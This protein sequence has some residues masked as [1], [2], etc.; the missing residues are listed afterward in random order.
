MMDERLIISELCKSYGRTNVLSHLSMTLEP[1]ITGLLGA[2]GAGK[3]T[4]MR[5]LAT[6]QKPDSGSITYGQRSWKNANDVRALVGYIPQSFSMYPLLTV[7]EVLVHIAHMKEIPTKQIAAE[8][9]RVLQA[10]NLTREK[11]KYVKQLSGGMLRRLG[12]AQC[13]LGNPPILLLDE[14]T[15]GLDP[16]EQMR[17]RKMLRDI[18]GEHI[19]LL[20]SHIVSDIE[21]VCDRYAILFGQRIFVEGDW[22]DA[23][24]R[25]LESIYMEAT[26]SDAQ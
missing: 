12:I 9:E 22:P 16:E 18:S 3:T 13:M 5:M 19:V 2:N 10:T 6:V 4:L 21:A 17:F 24:G 7:R 1:G 15:V 23:Q 26:G 25:S 20:S 8:V 14:P 11:R